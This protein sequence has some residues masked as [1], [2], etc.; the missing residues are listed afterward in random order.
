MGV[1]SARKNSD[2]IAISDRK[3]CAEEPGTELEGA[4]QKQFE[5]LRLV[6]RRGGHTEES[7][8]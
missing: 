2:I 6:I 4:A 8:T 3:P 5:G 1:A 7:L